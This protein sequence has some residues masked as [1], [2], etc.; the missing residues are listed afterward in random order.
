MCAQ[1]HWEF[2]PE[3]MFN[4]IYEKQNSTLYYKSAYTEFTKLFEDTNCVDVID[5]LISSSVLHTVALSSLVPF[6]S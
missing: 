4:L 2:Q 3:A 1:T 5:E 6:I